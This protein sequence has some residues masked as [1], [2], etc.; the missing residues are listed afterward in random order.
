MCDIIIPGGYAVTPTEW[1]KNNFLDLTMQK[2]KQ[3]SV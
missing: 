1:Q 3:N 2:R